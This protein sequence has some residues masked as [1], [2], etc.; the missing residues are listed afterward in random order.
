MVLPVKKQILACSARAGREFSIF[1]S[2]L[3]HSIVAPGCFPQLPLTN[4]EGKC[5]KY[6]RI[7]LERGRSVGLTTGWAM[8]FD[9]ATKNNQNVAFQKN[10]KHNSWLGTL[11]P[12]RYRRVHARG[13]LLV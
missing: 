3:R 7:E 6:T 12:L 13:K 2:Q 4:Q 8:V 9:F 10:K 1:W 5:V 11:L